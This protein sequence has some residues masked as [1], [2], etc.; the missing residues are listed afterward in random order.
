MKNWI[1]T[2]PLIVV[3]S[4]YM[5][6][7]LGCTV[8]S[9]LLQTDLIPYA[10]QKKGVFL[11][12]V[13]SGDPMHDRVII[14]TRVTP[15]QD[16]PFDVEW[17]MAT[18][19]SFRYVVAKGS[20]VTSSQQDY[21]VKVDAAGLQPG[22]SYAYRFKA[23]GK[24]SPVGHTK[25]LPK[26]ANQ[27]KFAVVSCSNFEAGY[28]NAFA[29]IADRKDIDAVLHLGD[30][31][32]EYGIGTYG[33]TTL[34]R[35]HVPSG[36]I[37]TLE[38]YRTRYSLYRLDKDFQN[39][40]GQHPFIVIWD[41]HE[42]TNNA[43]RDGAQNHQ[44][45]EGDYQSRKRAARQAYYE[46]MPI[47]ESNTLYRS[48]AYGDLVNLIMLDERYIGRTAP[49]DSAGAPNLHAADRTMLGSEQADWLLDQLSQEAQWRLVGNQVIFSGLY[50]GPDH[51][52]EI[53]LD[54]WDGW[55]HEQQR[56]KNY[57]HEQQIKNTVFVTGDTHSA[58]G[59]ET[60]WQNESYGSG[61]ENVAVELGTTSVSSGNMGTS[62]PDAVVEKRE[63]AFRSFN[64]HLKYVRLRDHGY[65]LVTIQEQFATAE[66]MYVETI[67]KPDKG[68][69]LG[70][71]FR[72]PANVSKLQSF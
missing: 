24:T 12:G 32:Y 58:W 16:G 40:H 61:E 31:I 2:L 71:R 34:G 14:W 72:I 49:V 36:E 19:R 15:L 69:Y 5:L 59:I 27:A 68:E 42:I 6:F 66:W 9:P 55:P 46:W 62:N 67:R 53:N 50:F 60:P 26:T 48:F 37:L 45:D 18:D 38:D 29:R 1:K 20:T 51:W 57:L 44:S 10:S 43:Y 41:D 17:E 11:H 13:A 30:Y 28:F 64:P 8:Q 21:T 54:S 35:L 25:T 47:R 70:Q 22:T 65:L 3:V 56:I 63:N 39:V 33:D 52:S 23:K 4:F 7:G